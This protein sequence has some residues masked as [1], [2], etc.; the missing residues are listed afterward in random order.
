MMKKPQLQVSDYFSLLYALTRVCTFVS[1]FCQC[2]IKCADRLQS[3]L[4]VA[5]IVRFVPMPL[6]TTETTVCTLTWTTATGWTRGAGYPKTY[7]KHVVYSAAR[8]AFGLL[9]VRQQQYV[10][11][12]PLQPSWSWSMPLGERSTALTKS[13]G[14]DGNNHRRIPGIYEKAPAGALDR[15][16]GQ[17]GVWAF[18]GPQNGKDDASVFPW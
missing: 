15:R 14:G 5:R 13:Q 10:N 18:L 1:C 8:T 4:A 3:I 16:V 17:W 7:K 6:L 11:T 12:P 9:N 2:H